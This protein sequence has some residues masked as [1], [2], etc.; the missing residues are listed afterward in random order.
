[1]LGTKLHREASGLARIV[2]SVQLTPAPASIGAH[3][4]CQLMV[5]AQQQRQELRVLQE[6]MAH[7]NVSLILVEKRLSHRDRLFKVSEGDLLRHITLLDQ[8]SSQR[9]QDLWPCSIRVGVVRR[10]NQDEKSAPRVARS[11]C[12]VSDRGE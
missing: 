11:G 12:F 4:R 2:G 7:W 5:D 10:V 9:H 1:M 6:G 8:F 3:L